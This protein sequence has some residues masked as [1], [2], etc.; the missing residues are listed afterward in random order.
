MISDTIHYSITETTS[1]IPL[2]AV[3]GSTLLRYSSIVL[4]ISCNQRKIK[5]SL[6][7]ELTIADSTHSRTLKL[8]RGSVVNLMGG[9]VLLISNYASQGEYLVANFDTIFTILLHPMRDQTTYRESI[10][11]FNYE[12]QLNPDQVANLM[13]QIMKYPQLYEN[14]LKNIRWALTTDYALLITR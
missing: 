11:S 14:I 5:D 3:V 2:N 9:C 1:F 8:W 12:K 10:A 4:L 7:V 6:L 13:P